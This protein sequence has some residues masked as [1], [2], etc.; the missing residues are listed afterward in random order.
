MIF[1]VSTPIQ[2]PHIMKDLYIKECH[3]A[4]LDTIRHN[5]FHQSY[6]YRHLQLVK[7]TLKVNVENIHITQ[8]PQTSIIHQ[9]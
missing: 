1:Y 7:L 6:I 4:F 5:K 3:I 2:H 8:Y 9:E